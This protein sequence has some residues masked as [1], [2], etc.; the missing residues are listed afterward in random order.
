ML[1]DEVYYNRLQKRQCWGARFSLA[2][3]KNAHQSDIRAILAGVSSQPTSGGLGKMRGRPESWAPP[4]TF[5]RL[6][7]RQA[8]ARQGGG[9]SVIALKAKSPRSPAIASW[10]S[11]SRRFSSIFNFVAEAADYMDENEPTGFV[12]RS[13]SIL[14]SILPP[15]S[16]VRRARKRLASGTVASSTSATLMSIAT[17][18]ALVS[19]TCP[20]AHVGERD[21][22]ATDR[23][24]NVGSRDDEKVRATATA[25]LPS[26]EQR[27]PMD[28]RCNPKIAFIGPN[29]VVGIVGRSNAK[30]N[31]AAQRYSFRSCDR[32]SERSIS[33]NFPT[34][35]SQSN[36]VA[37]RL[38]SSRGATKW[39]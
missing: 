39:A 28:N 24:R 19:W 17:R 5:G 8:R 16:S 33:T 26:R 38:I 11:R 21:A 36:T 7:V 37:R 22:R 23:T 4:G 15:A 20:Q 25:R 13:T 27:A 35:S 3:D 10:N 34:G 18:F 14:P 1:L 9:P 12:P 2:P 32:K 6:W 29:Q 30:R 31:G